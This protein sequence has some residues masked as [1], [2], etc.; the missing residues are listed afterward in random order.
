MKLYIKE[1]DCCGNCP[2]CYPSDFFDNN[3]KHYCTG[4][5]IAMLDLKYAIYNLDSIPEW[6]PL[7]DK[8]IITQD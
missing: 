2:N 8:L 4:R 1:I 6:C 3:A 7:S 5:K